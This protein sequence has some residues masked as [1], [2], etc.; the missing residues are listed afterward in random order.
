MIAEM[1]AESERQ[2]GGSA[3]AAGVRAAR[4]VAL[5]CGLG[6]AL[7]GCISARPRVQ[8]A[9]GGAPPQ[10]SSAGTAVAAYTVSCPDVLE[11]T[12]PGRPDWTGTVAVDADGSV[13]LPEFGRL[14]VEGRTA[15]EV[16]VQVAAAEGPAGQARVRVVEFNSRQVFLFGPVTGHERAVP[17]QGPETVVD[18]L[19]RTGGLTQQAELTEVHVVRPNVAVGRRPEVFPVDLEAILLRGD[20]RSDVVVQPYDQVYVGETRRSALAK[21]LPPWEWWR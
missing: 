13:G 18:L 20:D 16:A 11:L 14:R 1:A 17:Y 7:G 8:A 3:M 19:R 21:Y 5:A 2:P 4:Q 10:S 6:L 12:V 15:A 9:L